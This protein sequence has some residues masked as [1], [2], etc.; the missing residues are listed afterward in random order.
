MSKITDCGITIPINAGQRAIADIIEYHIVEEYI[1]KGGIRPKSV[2]TIE[3]VC[4]NNKL[5]DIKTRDIDRE[6]SM[7][8]LISVARLMKNKDKHIEYQFVEYQ[9]KDNIANIT[10]IENRPIHTIC[11]TAMKIQNLGL[12]Q[13]QL[14]T[15]TDIPY[16]KGTKDE[17]YVELRKQMNAFYKRQIKKFERLIAE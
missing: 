8:N 10:H 16:Y 3:D 6:F 12:G 11:W 17:W 14:V 4:F 7:P 13:L 2:R 15:L 5:I 1:A 9:V